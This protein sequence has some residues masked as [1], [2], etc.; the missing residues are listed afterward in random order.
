MSKAMAGMIDAELEAEMKEARAEGFSGAEYE[1][2]IRRRQTSRT[3][4]FDSRNEVS[5]DARYVAECVSGRIITHMW[6][7]GVLVPTV[8]GILLALL[9]AK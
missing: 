2:E 8:L 9:T 1:A 5:A 3:L 6:I 7:I 4:P